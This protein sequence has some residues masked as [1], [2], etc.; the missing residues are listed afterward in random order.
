[1]PRTQE[2]VDKYYH[3]NLKLTKQQLKQSVK[4]DNFICQAIANIEEI[5]KA[6]NLLSKRLREWYELENPELSNRVGD[7]YRLAELIVSGDTAKEPGS[8]GSDL[9]EVDHA[10]IKELAQKIADL[11]SLRRTH[12]SYLEKTMQRLCPNIYAI[13]GTLIGAKLIAQAGSLK[14]LAELTASTVQLLGAEKALFRHMVTGARAPKHG[15]ILQHPLLQKAK[16]ADRGKVARALA[17]K[18]AMAAKIDYFKG[19]FIGDKL[20]ADLEKKFSG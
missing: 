9:S 4:T 15:I 16:L 17:D 3:A 20:K 5:D 11:Y 7:H 2:F 13:T 12:E 8:M 10:P 14:R 6:A 1:M 19:Q 18:I